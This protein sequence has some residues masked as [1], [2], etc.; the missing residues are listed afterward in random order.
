[1]TYVGSNHVAALGN[2]NEVMGM[3]EFQTNAIERR[4]VAAFFLQQQEAVNA[5]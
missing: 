2:L 1:M 4:S 5:E 3:G